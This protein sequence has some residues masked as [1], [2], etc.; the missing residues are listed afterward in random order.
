MRLSTSLPL[1]TAIALSI[2]GLPAL[3]AA[4]ARAASVVLGDQGDFRMTVEIDEDESALYPGGYVVYELTASN[5][6]P[7]DTITVGHD[8]VERVTPNYSL[9]LAYGIQ[10]HPSLQ[11]VASEGFF[12]PG[13]FGVGGTFLGGT[14]RD[15]AADSLS[16]LDYVGLGAD[17]ARS[18][19]R[20]QDSVSGRLHLSIPTDASP[21]ATYEAGVMVYIGSRYGG[22]YGRGADS[23]ASFDV[24]PATETT[25]SLTV[26]PGTV[27]GR[28][29]T[30]TA[31]V[32][33]EA[34]GMVRFTVEDR[35]YSV[36]LVGGVA[37]AAHTFA[38]VGSVP[39]HAEFVPAHAKHLNS[40]DETTVAIGS[41]PVLPNP[42]EDGSESPEVDTPA[43]AGPVPGSLGGGSLI[44]L[45]VG[46]AGS[47]FS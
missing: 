10:T 28:P 30:L 20:G 32:T 33:P 16:A 31:R 6:S 22:G 14:P 38:T 24:L 2:G 23:L 43:P 1:L 42:D 4:E 41:A 9:L 11:L 47:S 19:I 39:V 36:A 27:A 26:E 13:N 3:A 37:T 21:G 7:R 44:G 18:G 45:V 34:E 40:H 35:E 17:I 46:S 5:P 29:T 8:G 25:T 12:A 15:F